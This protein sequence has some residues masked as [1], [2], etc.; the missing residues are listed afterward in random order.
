MAARPRS[1]IARRGGGRGL[2]DG[3]DARR[4]AAQERL[5]SHASAAGAL[6]LGQREASLAAGDDERVALDRDDL[7]RG[8]AA[9]AD[10]RRASR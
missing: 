2:E 5:G 10:E 3:A 9:G 7:A 1:S 4:P 6:Q 8:S